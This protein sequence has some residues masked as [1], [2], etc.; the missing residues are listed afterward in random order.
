MSFA[1]L[2]CSF[3]KKKKGNEKRGARIAV[4]HN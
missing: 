4:E 3:L 2:A 1:L